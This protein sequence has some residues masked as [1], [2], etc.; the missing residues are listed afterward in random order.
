MT[1]PGAPSADYLDELIDLATSV[2]LERLPS[3][4]VHQGRRILVDT[5]G[6][7][8]EGMTEPPVR[9][10]AERMAQA[11]I[12]P[13]S[14]ILGSGRRAEAMWAALASATSGVWHE[15]DPGHRFVDAN[16]AVYAVAAGLAVG[17]REKASGKGLL[18]AI[19]AGYEL[20]VRTGLGTTLR[21]GMHPHGSWPVVAAAVTAG[22]LMGHGHSRLRETVNVSTTVS[23]ATSSRTVYEGASIRSACAGFGSAMGVFAADLVRDGFTGE[24]DGITTVFGDIAG[25][26][27]DVEKCLDGMGNRW[28]IERGYHRVHAC[29]R[30]VQPALD[31]LIDLTA[32]QSIPSESIERI[33]VHTYAMA[34][35]M[36]RV[37]PENGLAAKFSIPHA[38]AAHLIIGDTG[39]DAFSDEAVNDPRIKALRSRVTVQR[40]MKVD[41]RTPLEL[42][43]SVRVF[44]RNGETLEHSCPV[45]VG[46][47]DSTPLSDEAL[48]RKFMDLSSRALGPER[49]QHLLERLWQIETVEDIRDVIS[50]TLPLETAS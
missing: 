32:G 15:L 16:V 17:E 41:G 8:L 12:A 50:L 31:A 9:A 6:V 1:T 47:D 24:R 48:N 5:V 45:A 27:F 36:S 40:E 37:A 3:R 13:S 2:S 43:A 26:Y 28:E 21:P 29:A 22:L 7:I 44:L 33:E 25:V 19:L 4:V 20:G 18:E 35:T 49:A 34:A 38:L 14:T 11:S 10:L 46:E 30:D 42:P 39:V 23:L